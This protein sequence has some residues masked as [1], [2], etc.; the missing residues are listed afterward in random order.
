MERVLDRLGTTGLKLK[1]KKCQLFQEDIPF[2]GHI[3]SS[4]GIG[5]D[6]ANANRYR[7]GRSPESYKRHDS[8]SDYVRATEDI[9]RALRS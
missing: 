9:F 2:L 6:P 7:I 8:S 5:A 1:A 4:A 3:V